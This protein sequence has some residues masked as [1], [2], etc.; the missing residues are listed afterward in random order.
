[1]QYSSR[2][3][4][5]IVFGLSENL[6]AL[7]DLQHLRIALRTEGRREQFHGRLTLRLREIAHTQASALDNDR[8]EI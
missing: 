6:V 7:D 2:P 1:M 8:R 5:L 3:K 4:M